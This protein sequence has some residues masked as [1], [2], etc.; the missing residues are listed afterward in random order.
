MVPARRH[1]H[2][3]CITRGCWAAASRFSLSISVG[4]VVGGVGGREYPSPSSFLFP[5]PTA[6]DAH[7]HASE[8]VCAAAAG[9]Q[10]SDLR[11][12]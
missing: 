5:V 9:L 3:G 6:T 7:F 4:I 1:E 12:K 10:V 11:K 2:L 8:G